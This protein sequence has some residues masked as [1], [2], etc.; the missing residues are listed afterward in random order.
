MTKSE[1]STAGPA[2]QTSQQTSA[3]NPHS[4]STWQ[5]FSFS[6]CLRWGQVAEHVGSCPRTDRCKLR[7]GPRQSM[8]RSGARGLQPW[9]T[10]SSFQHWECLS[11]LQISC[12]LNSGD[13]NQASTQ[14]GGWL[15]SAFPGVGQAREQASVVPG[16]RG[17]VFP[18]SVQSSGI[19]ENT[20][21]SRGRTLSFSILDSFIQ[22][23]MRVSW[24]SL[25]T[26]S[27]CPGSTSQPSAIP[28]LTGCK[29]EGLPWSP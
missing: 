11:R 19:P 29:W 5:G 6:P 13:R 18:H 21:K 1:S 22:G 4:T 20:E 26:M 2:K 9:A 12:V 10:P 25:Q 7:W 28:L 14:T 23:L 8:P 17:P 16:P 27:Q 3:Y 24:L 15:P